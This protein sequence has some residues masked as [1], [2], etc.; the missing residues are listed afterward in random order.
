MP[1]SADFSTKRDYYAIL[2]VSQDADGSDLKT[3]F[4]RLAKE[5]HHDKTAGD[6]QKAERFKEV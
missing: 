4:F 2:G 6:P 3:A 1:S 5:L